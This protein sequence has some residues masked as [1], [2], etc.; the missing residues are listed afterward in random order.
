MIGMADSAPR[1]YLRIPP[2]DLPVPISGFWT[3][4]KDCIVVALCQAV[5]KPVANVDRIPA[6][7]VELLHKMGSSTGSADRLRAEDHLGSHDR[8]LGP[9]NKEP[10]A[11]AD[12]AGV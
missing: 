8:Q 5:P 11:L 7:P 3:S 4:L 1:I 9:G 12:K 10:L 6:D 2:H